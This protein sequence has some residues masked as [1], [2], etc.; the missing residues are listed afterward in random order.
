MSSLSGGILSARLANDKTPKTFEFCIKATT[1]VHSK[2]IPDLTFVLE[3]NCTNV[4]SKV[5]TW[6]LPFEQ[7]FNNTQ[8]LKNLI[9]P[10]YLYNNS[11]VVHCPVASYVLKNIGCLSGYTGDVLSLN[12]NNDT[13][14]KTNSKTKV[15]VHFC[16]EVKNKH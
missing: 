15:E 16:I 9:T 7:M 5:Q 13:F 11:D 1:S 4:L 3:A 14:V 8:E 10:S 2:T 12:Q 6:I